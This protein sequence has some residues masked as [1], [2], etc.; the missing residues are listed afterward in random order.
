MLVGRNSKFDS[1]NLFKHVTLQKIILFCSLLP[2]SFA[3]LSVWGGIEVLFLSTLGLLITIPIVLYCARITQ[4]KGLLVGFIFSLTFKYV[5]LIIKLCALNETALIMGGDSENYIRGVYETDLARLILTYGKDMGFV[6]FLKFIAGI[7]TIESAQLPIAFV[8]PNLFA[9]SILTVFAIMFVRALAPS[10]PLIYIFWIAT[11]DLMVATYSTVVLKDVLVAA[12][13]SV[14][15]VVFLNFKKHYNYVI[16]GI[17]WFLASIA[18]FLLRFR[19]SG[20]ISGFILLRLLY[21]KNISLKKKWMITITITSLYIIFSIT[22]GKSVNILNTFNKGKSIVKTETLLRERAIERGNIDIR[23][24]GRLGY[25]INKLPSFPMRTG[26]RTVMSFLAPIPP[27]QF[28]QFSWGP[29]SN[30][31]QARLF[32]DLGGIFWYIIMP[33]LLLGA[34]SMFRTKDYFVPLSFIL[35]IAAMGLSGWVDA[36]VRLMAILPA[37]MLTL[38]G[39]LNYG[40][41]N[42]FSILFYSSLIIFWTIYELLF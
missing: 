30:G 36:R 21:N 11:L 23:R 16:Q 25:L 15:F 28:Y 24:S 39:L 32:K 7:F 8:I 1:N 17:L 4:I 38:K 22:I 12:L 2:L 14:S 41:W 5:F 34:I 42:R 35:V 10:I 20:I 40:F 6:Y 29:G 26:A 37:Y 31:L 33:L 18:S 3:V 19:S 9:G 27:A 13:T